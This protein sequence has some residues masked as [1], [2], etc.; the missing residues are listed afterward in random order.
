MS[1]C[2]VAAVCCEKVDGLTPNV[3][4]PVRPSENS[5]EGHLG[6]RCFEEGPRF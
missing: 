5:V 6:K 1:G 2:G 3:E 4:V